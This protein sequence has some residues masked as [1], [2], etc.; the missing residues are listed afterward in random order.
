MCT[1]LGWVL[2]KAFADDD[3]LGDEREPARGD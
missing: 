3:I 1:T 2:R